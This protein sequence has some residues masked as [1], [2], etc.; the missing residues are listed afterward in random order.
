M[1]PRM[2]V[3]GLEIWMQV[4]G[5]VDRGGRSFG[6]ARHRSAVGGGERLRL[7]VFALS[8]LLFECFVYVR[9]A[10]LR[11]LRYFS[12]FW[13]H[14]WCWGFRSIWLDRVECGEAS[15]SVFEVCYAQKH[16][17]CLIGV[18]RGSFESIQGVLSGLEIWLEVLECGR[19]HLRSLRVFLGLE[20]LTYEVWL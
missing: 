10:D 4:G 14:L 11:A 7:Y 17:T 5:G 8:F 20:H 9:S 12:S 1:G 18:L 6:E 2:Q 13:V 19:I 16:L 3:K 15:L